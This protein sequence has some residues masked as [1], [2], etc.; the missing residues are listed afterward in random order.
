MISLYNDARFSPSMNVSMAVD[1]LEENKRPQA[2][3]GCGRCAK[4]CPQ[5]IDIP[6]AMTELSAILEKVPHWA[7]F[8]KQRDEAARRAR[9]NHK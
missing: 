5:K 8:C 2:C 7:E 9:E 4:I 3:A 1:S 6:A